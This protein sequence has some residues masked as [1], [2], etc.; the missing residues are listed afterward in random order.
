MQAQL[1]IGIDGGGTKCRVRIRDREG[2][3]LGEGTGGAANVR[4][5][6][7]LVW[8]SILTA[9][10]DALRAAQLDEAALAGARVGLGLAGASQTLDAH[11]I[12]SYRHPFGPVALE[13]DAH[14]AWRGAFGGQDGAILIL[15]TGSCGYGRVKGHQHYVGGWGFEVSDEGSGAALGR[16]ALRRTLWA[17]DGRVAPTNLALAILEQFG[18]PEAIVD[19]V[20]QARPSD[21]GRLAPLV[22]DHARC[23]DPLAE[24][25][26]AYTVE[27]A[28]RIARR[29]LDL[30][31]PALCLVGGLAE[32]LR[33]WLP[34]P[35][36]ER[37]VAPQADALDG[38]IA[39][40]R[41][42]AVPSDRRA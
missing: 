25:L 41:E 35:L 11:R 27:G 5:A 42:A 40:A 16:E 14:V 30:G 8:N 37:I 17:Y 38:A 23:G 39:L 36:L 24:D 33:A 12:L 15:G 21:Y 34:K 7:E 3:L 32:P 28:V 22:L 1:L 13:T 31:A 4:L 2:R 9:C 29:L 19:W 20:G 10:R 6:T 26:V 18:G